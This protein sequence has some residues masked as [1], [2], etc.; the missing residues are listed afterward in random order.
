MR[1]LVTGGCG[2]IGSRLVPK[3]LGDGHHVTVVDPQYFGA[4]DPAHNDSLVL[5]RTMLEANRSCDATIWL[6]SLSNN[7]MY[8]RDAKLCEWENLMSIQN[9]EQ[10]RK[11]HFGRFIYASS[12]AVYG[13][14]DE[15]LTDSS[16]LKPTT[17]YG[18]DKAKCED[19][20]RRG[21]G[22]IVRAASVYGHSPNMRFD[23]PV[24][25]M[26]RDA[27]NK[28]CVQVNGGKQIRCHIHIDDLCD[29]Y[30]L[31]LTE[32]VRGEAFNAVERSLPMGILGKHIAQLLDADVKINPA[33]DDRS[34]FVSG[35]KAKEIIGFIPKREIAEGVKK[36]HAHWAAGNPQ[37]REYS[38]ARMRML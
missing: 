26:T 14:S 17:P 30:R 2:Y 37:Y 11:Y 6:G 4:G 36:M 7:G 34:Y 5:C 35:D 33:T 12:V 23:T 3:L 24:N 13:T 1:I 8:E 15:V 19:M 25:S 31:L 32:D 9:E 29:L 18:I 38:D 16:P 10:M 22:T 21:G 20:V 27:L 28:R